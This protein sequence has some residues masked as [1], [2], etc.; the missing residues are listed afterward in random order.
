M[1]KGA[2]NQ[3]AIDLPDEAPVPVAA[4]KVKLPLEGWIGAI[5]VAMLLLVALLAPVIAPAPPNEM[6]LLALLQWPTW[7]GEPP[8]HLLGTDHLGRDILSRL[9]WG[10]RITCTVAFLAALGAACFGTLLGVLAG[11]GYQREFML[12]ARP[13]LTEAI[14]AI[15]SRPPGQRPS[16]RGLQTEPPQGCGHR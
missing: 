15:R 11:H 4:R 7:S 13:R 6:D 12:G 9:M 14:S 8:L 10:A 3:P 16:K 5:L 2:F 1:S